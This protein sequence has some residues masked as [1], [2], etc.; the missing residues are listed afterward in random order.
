MNIKQ[1][2]NEFRK[3]IG[4][5]I[6]EL[7]F[8]ISRMKKSPLSIVGA[9]I[10][11]FYIAIAI[12]A[13]VLAPPTSW[14]PYMIPR[15]GY[16]SE[17]QAPSEKHI[18]GTAQGQYD[19][20]YGCI[21]GTRTAFRIGFLVV[22]SA[23]AMGIVIGVVSGYYGGIYD[24]VMMRFTDVIYAFPGLILV[25]ALVIAVPVTF[26]FHIGPLM[27][28]IAGFIACFIGVSI[29]SERSRLRLALVLL[30]LGLVATAIATAVFPG[31]M[32]LTLGS[33]MS[34]RF[35]P[36]DKVMLA[37]V[38]VGWPTYSRV[39]RGEI[40]RVK[41]EDYVEAAKAV[42]CSDARIIFRHILPNSIYPL[43]I[44]A[45]LDIGAIVLTAAALSFLGLGAP[46]GYADWGQMISFSRNWIAV[47]GNYYW[48]TWLTPGLFIFI[49]VLGWNLLGDAFR[50]VSDPT[51]RRR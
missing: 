11:V 28:I 39:M 8:M 24:E 36:L 5:T 15:E 14:D 47:R 25:M 35:T 45:S 2:L 16:K 40:L 22:L 26:R 17:P 23:V 33:L 50:D 27:L 34:F 46:Q 41:Q 44:M 49:F 48:F 37:L 12:L 21:W 29:G 19:I 30:G 1:R 31:Q 38:V 32:Y 4:P 3:G 18:F 20:F 7:K 9:A 42:G 6:K 43:L 51:L 13:P 10:L